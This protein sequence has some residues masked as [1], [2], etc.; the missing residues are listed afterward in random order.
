MREFIIGANDAG[1]RLDRFVGKAVPLLPESLLQ[2]S[3]RLKRIKL[4]GKAAKGDTRISEGDVIRLFI[5]DE[6]FQKP[7]ADNAWRKISVPHVTVLF[8]DKNILLADKPE[9]MLCH[10][11]GE[12]DFNTLIANIKAYLYQSGQW[13]PDVENSFAPALCNRIDR[14]TSGIVIAAKNAAAL[15]ILDEKIRSRELKKLYL[16]AI[17]GTLSPK[18]GELRSFIF[19]DSKEN[20]V[21]IKKAPEKGAR[22]AITQYRTLQEQDGL[23][24]LECHLITGRTHQIRAQLAAIGHPLLGDGKYGSD[25]GVKALNL[26]GQALCS[27]S[28]RFDFRTSAG[29]LQYLDGRTFTASLPRFI[30]VLFPGFCYPQ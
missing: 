17:H 20:R 10:S 19:K 21:Y 16:A 4:N 5:A 6:F 24:L 2:K 26:P 23:S 8:E 3:I 14:N 28:L 29:P 13:D 11:A 25:N 30:S 9:G 7:T 1:Q 27:Y 12:W 22:T 15:R 18:D